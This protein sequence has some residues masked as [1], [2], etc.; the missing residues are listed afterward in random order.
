ML[1]KNIYFNFITN[2]DNFILITSNIDYLNICKYQLYMLYFKAY[3]IQQNN[4]CSIWKEIVKV[5]KMFVYMFDPNIYKDRFYLG[6]Y[7]H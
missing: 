6:Y 4:T 7:I 2:F 3:F 5:V 1:Q